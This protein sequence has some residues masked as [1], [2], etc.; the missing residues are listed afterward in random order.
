MEKMTRAA[1]GR[2]EGFALDEFDQDGL[3]NRKFRRQSVTLVARRKSDQLIIG[4]AVI[5][6]SA[7]VRAMEPSSLGGYIVVGEKYRRQGYGSEI[8]TLCEHVAQKLD[9]RN[10]TTDLLV[11]QCSN[12]WSIAD[13]P[14]GRICSGRPVHGL[15]F[16]QEVWTGKQ[17]NSV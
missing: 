5:G 2:G 4:G 12:I 8:M 7:L 17:F 3:L 16:P 1:A 10:I 15:R 14:Q 9:D 13:G 6:P 11:K